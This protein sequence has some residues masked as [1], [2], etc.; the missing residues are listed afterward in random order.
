LEAILAHE[1]AH[2]IRHDYLVKLLQNF[3]H[4]LLYYHPAMWWMSKQ[5][6]LERENCC[7]DLAISYTKNPLDFAKAIVQVEEFQKVTNKQQSTLDRIQ[8]LFGKPTKIYVHQNHKIMLVLFA[9]LIL[10]LSFSN[11]SDTLTYEQQKMF[12]I[13]ECKI[14][15]SVKTRD[16]SKVYGTYSE[17]TYDDNGREK[18]WNYYYDNGDLYYSNESVYDDAGR[19]IKYLHYNSNNEYDGYYQFNYDDKGNEVSVQNF[20]INDQLK[21]TWEYTTNGKG[22]V[23]REDHLRANGSLRSYW[24]RSYDTQGNNIRK[25]IYLPSGQLYSYMESTYDEKGKELTFGEYYADGRE[26]FLMRF[27]YD[28]AE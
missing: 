15:K 19:R 26:R 23:I 2:I 5:I 11:Q 1:L 25:D 12:G 13:E 20:D 8:R 6:D 3:V 18:R 28:C 22:Q 4:S 17:F 16:N 21:E 7:D 27:E 9:S 10:G 24:I 14:V